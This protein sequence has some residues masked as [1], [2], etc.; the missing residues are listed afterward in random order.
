MTHTL[1]PRKKLDKDKWD[2]SKTLRESMVLYGTTYGSIAAFASKH[3]LKYASG[4]KKCSFKPELWDETKTRQENADLQGVKYSTVS[5]W[6]R[7]FKLNFRYK[8][9]LPQKQIITTMKRKPMKIKESDKVYPVSQ[10]R[11]VLLDCEGGDY[12]MV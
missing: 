12:G 8:L 3:G 11:E 9:R 1:K 5:E 7:I 2:N 10:H 4:R 6:I